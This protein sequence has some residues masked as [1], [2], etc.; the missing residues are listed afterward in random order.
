MLGLSTSCRDALR[1]L[2]AGIAPRRCRWACACSAGSTSDNAPYV[3]LPRAI[4]AQCVTS[5]LRSIR[6]SWARVKWVVWIT[7]GRVLYV[8]ATG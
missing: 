7:S 6:A 5:S 3:A 4:T 2:V 1:G 8:G